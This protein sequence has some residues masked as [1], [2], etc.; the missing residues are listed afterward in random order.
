M[1]WGSGTVRKVIAHWTHVAIVFG[2]KEM[3]GRAKMEFPI[4][5]LLKYDIIV[6]V[7]IT[8]NPKFIMISSKF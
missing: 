8:N 1:Q 4:F 2:I 3:K 6:M 7:S 5:L